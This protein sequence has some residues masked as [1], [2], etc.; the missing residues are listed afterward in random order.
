PG[1]RVHARASRGDLDDHRSA[2]PGAIGKPVAGRR[3]GPDRRGTRSRR[4]SGSPG[5]DRRARRPGLRTAGT[6]AQT[7]TPDLAPGRSGGMTT[8]EIA[9]CYVDAL[10]TECSEGLF[11]E[12]ENI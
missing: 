1:T 3:Y 11:A 5:S 6:A 7:F 9:H 8:D 12:V 2:H 10:H 4:R